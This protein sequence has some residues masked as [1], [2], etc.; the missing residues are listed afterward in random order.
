MSLVLF[1]A[2][3]LPAIF[4]ECVLEHSESWFALRQDRHRHN[5]ET[6][7]GIVE[8]VSRN[9]MVRGADDAASFQTANRVFR[10]FGVLAGFDLDEDEDRAVPCDDVHFPEF[11]SIS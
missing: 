6:V 8:A 11:G 7:R 2:G 5:V 4:P 3:V 1:A 9:V 10:R